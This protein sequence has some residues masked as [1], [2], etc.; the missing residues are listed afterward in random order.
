[1]NISFE[2]RLP[3]EDCLFLL[4]ETFTPDEL[5]SRVVIFQYAKKLSEKAFFLI[6]DDNG[7]R[8]GFIAYYLN[9]ELSFIFITRIAVN[10]LFRHQGLGRKMIEALSNHYSNRFEA[11]ELEVEKTNIIAKNFYLNLGFKTKEDRET[12]LLMRKELNGSNH[13]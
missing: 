7:A 5:Y 1:M 9:E 3:I 10:E 8:Q 12:K 2:A 11:I 4:G 13:R 6:V